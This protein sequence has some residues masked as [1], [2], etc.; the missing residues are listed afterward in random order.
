MTIKQPKFLKVQCN[1]Y[2]KKDFFISNKMPKNNILN[3]KQSRKL[4]YNNFLS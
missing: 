3:F 4:T 2:I 1:T